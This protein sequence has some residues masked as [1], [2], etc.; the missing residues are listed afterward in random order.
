M[1]DVFCVV[2][3]CLLYC[4]A[5]RQIYDRSNHLP[6]KSMNISDKRIPGETGSIRLYFIKSSAGD[7][8]LPIKKAKKT[9]LL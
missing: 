8:C 6:K 3:N 7:H 5:G 9:S 4:D 2:A 1:T